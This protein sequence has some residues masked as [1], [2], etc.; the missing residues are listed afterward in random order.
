M[1]LAMGGHDSCAPT[2]VDECA[3]SNNLDKAVKHQIIKAI[4][5]PDFSQTVGKPH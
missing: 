1:K 4:T 2:G 5:D 3:T